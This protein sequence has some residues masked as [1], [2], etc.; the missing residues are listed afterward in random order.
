[1]SE[2]ASSFDLKDGLPAKDPGASHL[3]QLR[4]QFVLGPEIAAGLTQALSRQL[5]A[6]EGDLNHL[7]VVVRLEEVRLCGED[8]RSS[9]RLVLLSELVF[10]VQ[11][12]R[13][14]Q[15]R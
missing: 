2:E 12:V 5:K 15:Q 9:E 14:L 13:A 8:P 10:L 4:M 11:H 3:H 6:E 7:A 1:M